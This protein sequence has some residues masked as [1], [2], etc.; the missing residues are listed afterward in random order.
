MPTKCSGRV[1]RGEKEV[2]AQN[3]NTLWEQ[4]SPRWGL[5]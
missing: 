5:I 4:G 1:L 3:F 2:R